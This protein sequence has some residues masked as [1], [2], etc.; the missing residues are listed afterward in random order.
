MHSA[1]EAAAAAAAADDDDNNDNNT[2]CKY[3]VHENIQHMP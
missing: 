1:D 3:M 2:F